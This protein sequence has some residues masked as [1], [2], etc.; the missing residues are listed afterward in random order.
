MCQLKL[1]IR[2]ILGLL[3]IMVWWKT[4]RGVSIV[5]SFWEYDW[6]RR[7]AEPYKMIKVTSD[8]KRTTATAS[9]SWEWCTWCCERLSRSLWAS[10]RIAFMSEYPNSYEPAIRLEDYFRKTDL[11]YFL[12][13]K[14]SS[15]YFSE[16]F[17]DSSVTWYLYYV[18]MFTYQR[19]SW[20]SVPEYVQKIN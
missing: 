4:M 16:G 1:E 20:G 3:T 13:A 9:C 19:I 12:L 7:I 8:R 6:L 18:A 17:C 2:C 11:S 14:P 15:G 10:R 5:V